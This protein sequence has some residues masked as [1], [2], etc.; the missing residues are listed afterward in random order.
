M[1]KKFPL[2]EKFK[3]NFWRKIEGTGDIPSRYNASAIIYNQ[4]LYI[5]GGWHPEFKPTNDLFKF[6]FKTLNWEKIETTGTPPSPRLGQES[7]VYNKQMIV[8][9]G[10]NDSVLFSDT[11]AYDF[12]NKNWSTLHTKGQKPRA[13]LD[14]IIAL[15]DHKMFIFG[16]ESEN[17]EKLNDVFYLDFNDDLKWIPVL[18]RKNAPPPMSDMA[19]AQVNHLLFIHGG[20]GSHISSDIYCFDMEK[21]K[22]KKKIKQKTLHLND[23]H[24]MIYFN[25]SLFVYGGSQGRSNRYLKRFVVFDLESKEW[26]EIEYQKNDEKTKDEKIGGNYN[27]NEIEEYEEDSEFPI[28]FEDSRIT[29]PDSQ[30][31][32]AIPGGKIGPCFSFV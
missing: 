17:S 12:E 19:G 5:F 25:N 13:R 26:N 10:S 2:S 21:L 22:W 24:K 28:L 9:F 30:S 31:K 3:K 7:I 20:M 15:W 27:F 18:N 23:D 29:L 8:C 11:F 4:E 6:S 1:I 16:G 14:P 32:P